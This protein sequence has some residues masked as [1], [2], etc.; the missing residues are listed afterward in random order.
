M[1]AKFY[2]LFCF[3]QLKV[4]KDLLYR[5]QK[6]P[7]TLLLP[8]YKICEK[9]CVDVSIVKMYQHNSSMVPTYFL[10]YRQTL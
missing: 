3:S 8:S 9:Q 5:G 7:G 10:P 1:Y 6:Q 4:F 2:R